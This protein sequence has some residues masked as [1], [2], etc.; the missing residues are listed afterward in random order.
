MNLTDWIGS[1]GVFLI[2]LAY[3]LN[4]FGK[5]S[6]TSI[7]FLL[8]NLFGAALAGLASVLLK[9]VPFIILESAWVLVSIFAIIKQLRVKK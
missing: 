9:Y 4:I 5:I 2:L 1:L 8:L 3:V 7:S 6:N